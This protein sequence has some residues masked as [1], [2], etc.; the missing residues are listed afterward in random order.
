M[1]RKI[2]LSAAMMAILAGC[3]KISDSDRRE[4]GSSIKD[5]LQNIEV[6]LFDEDFEFPSVLVGRKFAGKNLA[7][8]DALVSAGILHEQVQVL[9]VPKDAPKHLYHYT[10]HHQIELKVFDLTEVGRSFFRKSDHGGYFCYG[11]PELVEIDSITPAGSETEKDI[12]TVSFEYRVITPPDWV[13]N[14]LVRLEFPKIRRETDPNEPVIAK[15]PLIAKQQFSR[16]KEGAL[17][18]LAGGVLSEHTW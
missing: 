14:E 18:P 4:A 3:N 10:K 5:A 16:N 12:V 8:F 11:R 2:L 15:E 17:V 1:I 7:R 13:R 6:C 9:S